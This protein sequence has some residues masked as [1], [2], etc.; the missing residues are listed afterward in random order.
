MLHV[1]RN[2]FLLLS[3]IFL[4]SI[5]AGLSGTRYGISLLFLDPEYIGKE[6]SAVFAFWA[7]LWVDFLWCGIL[8][9]TF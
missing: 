5:S 8:P 4:I 9:V 1:K 3:W 2:H 7:L 6:I